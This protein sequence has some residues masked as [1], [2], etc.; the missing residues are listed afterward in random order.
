[1]SK[2]EFSSHVCENADNRGFRLNRDPNSAR[3]KSYLEPLPAGRLQT[4]PAFNRFC[5]AHQTLALHWL[6]RWSD[7]SRQS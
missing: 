1:M 4:T 5:Q 3:R 6:T 7:F 2:K